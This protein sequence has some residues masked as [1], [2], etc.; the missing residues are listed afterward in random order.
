MSKKAI[1][2]TGNVYGSNIGDHGSVTIDYGNK[3]TQNN[4]YPNKSNRRTAIGLSP[5]ELLFISFAVILFYADFKPLILA[6]LSVGN[7]LV[8]FLSLAIYSKYVP[9]RQAIG[10]VVSFSLST[11][12]TI[13]LSLDL[14]SPTVYQIFISRL[15]IEKAAI[16]LQPVQVSDPSFWYLIF[17]ALIVGLLLAASFLCIL[18]TARSFKGKNKNG[19]KWFRLEINRCVHNAITC[20]GIVLALG[21]LGILF[22]TSVSTYLI[23]AA[24]ICTK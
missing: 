10:L 4:Y 16:I 13:P 1:Q 9:K 18:K 17:Q 11:L 3:Y 21:F 24:Q 22:I 14:L 20:E 19:E 23:H 2:V 6:V 7:T 12:A 15:R 5:V 8:I